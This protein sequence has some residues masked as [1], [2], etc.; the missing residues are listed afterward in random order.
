MTDT[1]P[2]FEPIDPG[3]IHLTDPVEV[4]YWCRELACTEGQLVAAVTKVGEHVTAVR[5]E[6]DLK[7]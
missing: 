6:L 3:R 7:R 2:D 1:P 5:K 4:Q